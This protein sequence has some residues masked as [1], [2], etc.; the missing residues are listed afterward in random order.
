[1]RRGLLWALTASVLLT[2][3]ALVG[4]EAPRVV[5]AIEPRVRERAQSLDEMSAAASL[6]AVT[7][8]RLPSSI[9]QLTVDAARRDPF[10]S[11]AV[12]VTAVVVPA[13]AAVVAL[14]PLADPSPPPINLRFLGSMVSPGGQR[15]LYLARGDAAIEVKEGDHLDEGYKVESLTAENVTLVYP[16]LK[17]RLSIPIPPGPRQ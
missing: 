6:H 11:A 3:A 15:F 16:P 9:P 8:E 4:T 10:A 1:M 17:T 5:S 7:F 13:P 14:P 12:A 2:A